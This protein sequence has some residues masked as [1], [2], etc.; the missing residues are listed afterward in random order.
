M[1]KVMALG[2]AAAMLGGMPLVTDGFPVRMKS[3]R[4]PKPPTNNAA[5]ISKAERKRARK[6]EKRA[7][8]ATHLTARER[9][10]EDGR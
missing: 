7:R 9:T 5:A 2:L 1:K 8:L 10:K 4:G 6:M 3:S